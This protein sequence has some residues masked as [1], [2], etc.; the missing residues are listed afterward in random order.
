MGKTGETH[1]AL[2]PY[3]DMTEDTWGCQEDGVQVAPLSW[4]S[5]SLRVSPWNPHD[6]L[7]DSCPLPSLQLKILWLTVPFILTPS[8]TQTH[9]RLP[10]CLPAPVRNRYSSPSSW[11]GLRTF[12]HFVGDSLG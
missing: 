2:W 7:Q 12:N 6:R 1:T 3:L 5:L 4:M 11:F 9:M 8:S 10:T